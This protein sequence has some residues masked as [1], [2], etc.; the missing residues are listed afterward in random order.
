MAMNPETNKFEALFET[1]QK[2]EQELN[3]EL[4]R[5]RDL[6]EDS[7]TVLLRPNGEPVP[8][9]WTVLTAGEHVVVKDYTFKVAH[10][11]ESY[12]VLE[13]VGIVAIGEKGDEAR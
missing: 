13:P 11:G 9:H 5:I 3:R 12:L 10:I 4:V 2:S 8:K 1:K 7:G 6:V